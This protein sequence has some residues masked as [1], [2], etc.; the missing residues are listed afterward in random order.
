MATEPSV[1]FDTIMFSGV[2]T[3]ANESAMT[4]ERSSMPRQFTQVHFFFGV[5]LS[6]W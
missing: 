4:A 5:L 6:T 3:A 1:P 2:G